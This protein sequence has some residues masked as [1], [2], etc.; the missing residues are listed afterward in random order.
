M[1]TCFD[2]GG[3]AIKCAV[4]TADGRVGALQRVPTPVNDFAAFTAVMKALVLDGGPSRGIAISIAG[5]IDPADGRIKCANIPCIDGRALASDLAA[6][7]GLPVWIINDADSFALAEAHAGAGRGHANVFG[8][9]LGTGV[10]GGLV[11]NGKLIAG[12][13][14]FA[15]EW[16]HGP[17]AAQFA[18]RP[19]Q[20]IPRFACGCGQ[21]GCVD[22]VGGARGLE[23]LHLALHQQPL[24]SHAIINN[25]LAGDAHASHTIN[26]YIDLLS[27]PLAMLVN[28][29]GAS[30]LP[31][32]GGLANSAP[33][34]A[35]LDQ[36]VRAAILR[37]TT[38]PI[39]V[40]GQSGTE[41]GL[42]GAAWL[43]LE[44]LGIS[45]D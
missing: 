16:G 41:P 45:H 15:G 6:A 38:A 2:I 20:A 34:I 23:R 17:V 40:P 29:L 35:R 28:T 14:G 5:V 43:G 44:Q 25:W 24:D 10:G 36:A 27:G 8:L 9:I 22:T 18:G 12:P 7:L 39:I 30:I 31:V 32:G 21:V 26:C 33:L 1:I 3:S 37:K 19:P 11:I 42:I 13:G 4:A